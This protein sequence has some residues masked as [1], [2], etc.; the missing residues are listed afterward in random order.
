MLPPIPNLEVEQMEEEKRIRRLRRLVDFSLAFIAQA[1]LS[2]EEAQGVVEGVRR[3]AHIL[4]PDKQE[5]FELIYTP[6]FFRLI[7]EKFTLV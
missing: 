7:A 4:F 6:R 2:L 5:T 3:Q 1:R